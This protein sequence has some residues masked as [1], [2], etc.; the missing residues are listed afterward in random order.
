MKNLLLVTIFA[1]MTFSLFAQGF[2]D[3]K[4][5]SKSD[6]CQAEKPCTKCDSLMGLCKTAADSAKVQRYLRSKTI[7]ESTSHN[8]MV[9]YGTG[10]ENKK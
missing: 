4:R 1:A 9:L 7:Q 3:P 10:K 6:S 2:V 5:G 8:P